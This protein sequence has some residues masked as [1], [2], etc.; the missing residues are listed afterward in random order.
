M[1]LSTKAK[2]SMVSLALARTAVRPTDYQIRP[3]LRH[4]GLQF[5]LFYRLGLVCI[6]CPVLPTAHKTAWVLQFEVVILVHVDHDGNL[7]RLEFPCIRSVLRA[8]YLC[9]TR[10]TF[11]YISF[12]R[13]ATE[14]TVGLGDNCESAWPQRLTM[15]EVIPVRSHDMLIFSVPAAVIV[16]K[17]HF[18]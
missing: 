17:S 16:P 5:A 7:T 10:Q 3:A 4:P 9:F 15:C 8:G 14:A 18:L 1:P 6:V 2:R 12:Q 13:H 11:D